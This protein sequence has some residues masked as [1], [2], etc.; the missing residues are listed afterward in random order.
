MRLRTRRYIRYLQHRRNAKRRSIPW[1]LTFTQWS[2]IWA[3]SDHWFERGNKSS[4]YVMGRRGDI[5]PYNPSNV[6]II[7]VNENNRTGL[8]GNRSR[9]GQKLSKGTRAKIS[10]RLIGNQNRLGHTPSKETRAKISAGLMGNQN[11][12]NL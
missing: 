5:G 4:Q 9:T 8:I 2:F 7:T 10:S 1:L 11:A 12:S 3:R 6:V